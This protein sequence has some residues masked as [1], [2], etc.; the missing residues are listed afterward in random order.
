MIMTMKHDCNM[1]DNE[2]IFVTICVETSG[3]HSI[4]I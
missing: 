3:Q 4:E 1:S 2:Y